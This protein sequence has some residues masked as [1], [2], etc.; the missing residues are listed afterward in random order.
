[1]CAWVRSCPL[2]AKLPGGALVA[3]GLLLPAGVALSWLGLRAMDRR[4]LVPHR[5]LDLLR[6]KP[7][8]GVLLCLLHRRQS[9]HHFFAGRR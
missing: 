9:A 1:M 5:A 6:A 7:V 2:K 4:A 3:F 8:D